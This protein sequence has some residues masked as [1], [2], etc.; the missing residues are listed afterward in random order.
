M[1]SRIKRYWVGWLRINDRI[2]AR[3]RSWICIYLE[4][5]RFGLGIV[6]RDTVDS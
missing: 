6:Q 3:I 1:G 5:R 4:K 2:L